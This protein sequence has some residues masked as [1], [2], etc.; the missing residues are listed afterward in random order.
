[1]VGRVSLSTGKPIVPKLVR[2]QAA[3][4]I[5]IKP[6]TIATGNAPSPVNSF[7]GYSRAVSGSL[8]VAKQGNVCICGQQRLLLAIINI[9]QRMK[10]FGTPLLSTVHSDQF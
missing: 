10:R 6:P 3:T 5:L 1:M 9:Q 2:G 8:D 4:D 7:P